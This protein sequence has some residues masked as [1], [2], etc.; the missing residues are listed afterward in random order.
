MP[1]VPIGH[2]TTKQGSDVCVI[3]APKSTGETKFKHGRPSYDRWIERWILPKSPQPLFGALHGPHNYLDEAVEEA[4]RE[5]NQ[6]L[7]LKLT[8][9]IARLRRVKEDLR[10]ATERYVSLQESFAMLRVSAENLSVLYCACTVSR[11]PLDVTT[12]PPSSLSPFRQRAY[13]LEIARLPA[14]LVQVQCA[15]HTQ[16]RLLMS[17]STITNDL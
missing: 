12:Q 11:P 14:C 3:E 8:M 9:S 17:A 7:Q 13:G 6:E 16:T 15:P 1:C 4:M 5:A 2:G 10:L